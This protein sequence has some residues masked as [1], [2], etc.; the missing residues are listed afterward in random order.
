MTAV[1]AIVI[2]KIPRVLKQKDYFDVGKLQI[3]ALTQSAHPIS[4][5]Q[6]KVQKI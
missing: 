4:R 1:V 5:R 3:V 2:S 6:T